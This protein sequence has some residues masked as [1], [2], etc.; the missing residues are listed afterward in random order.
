MTSV[1]NGVGEAILDR[2][3]SVLYNT[4]GQL[5]LVSEVLENELLSILV[6]GDVHLLGRELWNELAAGAAADG[7]V[8][9]RCGYDEEEHEAWAF[10][11]PAEWW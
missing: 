8:L 5:V 2:I 7:F 9:L 11:R 6:T 4:N 1:W 3:A 10:Y